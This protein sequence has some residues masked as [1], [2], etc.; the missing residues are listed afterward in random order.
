MDFTRGSGFS[1]WRQRGAVGDLKQFT[2]SKNPATPRIAFVARRARSCGGTNT[3]TNSYVDTGHFPGAFNVGSWLQQDKDDGWFV[4]WAPGPRWWRGTARR[5][6][7]LS[8]S[9]SGPG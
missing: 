9:F 5:T 7:S 8:R 1:N 4:A 3:A 6:Q 2:F